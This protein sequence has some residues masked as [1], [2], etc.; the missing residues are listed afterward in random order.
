[1]SQADVDVVLDQIAA[2]NERDFERAMDHYAEDVVL[3]IEEG[4]L[5]RGTFEGKQAAGEW[6]GDWFRT[7]SEYHFDI[8]EARELEEGPIFVVASHRGSGR[9]SGAEFPAR[10]LAYLYRVVG[11]KVARLQ[12]FM[13]RD[14][15]LEAAALPEWSESEPR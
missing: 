7:L 12:L 8:E 3:V 4:F 15:A 1:V 11:G 13:S 2:V 6:F 9:A 5:N 10:E 14:H